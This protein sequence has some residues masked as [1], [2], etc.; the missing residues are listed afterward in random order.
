MEIF[1]V[2]EFIRAL[3]GGGKNVRA[4]KPELQNHR[5]GHMHISVKP[6]GHQRLASCFSQASC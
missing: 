6:D 4:A 1:F 3:L 2:E 5:A